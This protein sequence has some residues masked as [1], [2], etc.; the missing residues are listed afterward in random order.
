MK[1][2]LILSSLL[3]AIALG[4]TACT[5]SPTIS[6]DGVNDYD[7]A[8]DKTYAIIKTDKATANLQIG[9]GAIQA[10][11][12]GLT[13]ALAAKGLTPA[14]PADADIL[15]AMYL[16]MTDKV[17]INDF[18]Y[19]YGGYRGFGYGGAYMGGGVTATDYTDTSLVI[20]IVD[21]VK[22]TLVWRGWAQKD[23]YS[24]TTGTTTDAQRQKIKQTIADILANYPPPPVPTGK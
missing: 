9:P 16:K 21:N 20:D 22:D 13:A 7:F 4:F 23:I 11:Q 17:D 6:Y 2:K 10:A 19:G 14:S 1:N 8:K 3:G 15:V 18:G 24:S 12:E 5:T